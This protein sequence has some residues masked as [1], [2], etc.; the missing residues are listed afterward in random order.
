M[1]R[2]SSPTCAP[3]RTCAATGAIKAFKLISTP[4]APTGAATSKNKMLQRIYG[5][6]F[7]QSVRCLRSTSH[8]LEEAKK[9][10]HRKLG[11][12]LDLFDIY[13]EG[14]GFPFFLPKGM[15]LHN[16]LDRL[17]ARDPAHGARIPGDQNAH[18]PQPGRCGTGRGTGTTT[19]TICIS[20]KS[21][22]PTSP[23]SP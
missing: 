2:A 9:R 13:E 19:R 15:I 14:P 8:T 16:L 22:T 1:N 5:T 12:E 6:C 18:D 21:T 10:D 7:P 4:P 17:L 11:R 23:S 20:R 3:A